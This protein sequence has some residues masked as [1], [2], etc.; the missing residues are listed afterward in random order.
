[1]RDSN[2]HNKDHYCI[3]VKNLVKSYDPSTLK[4]NVI[5]EISF[6]IDYGTVFGF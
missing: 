2:S 6:D 4:R 3:S 1:M 5:G